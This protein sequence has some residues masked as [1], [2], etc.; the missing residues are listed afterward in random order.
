MADTNRLNTADTALER[1]ELF[2]RAHEDHCGN[3]AI[4]S[5]RDY[6]TT[7]RKT[8]T[9]TRTILNASDI[10]ELVALVRAQA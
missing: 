7:G 5:V 8:R 9:V 4:T 6:H 10:A 2:L 3:D 1:V